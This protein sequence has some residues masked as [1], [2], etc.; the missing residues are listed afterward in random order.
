VLTQP[1]DAASRA[2]AHDY[3]TGLLAAR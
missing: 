2:P 1:A 3:F